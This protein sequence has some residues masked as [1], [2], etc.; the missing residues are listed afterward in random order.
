MAPSSTEPDTPAPEGISRAQVAADVPALLPLVD[1]CPGIH[2]YTAASPHYAALAEA[3]VAST[4]V[5]DRALVRPTSEVEVAAAVRVCGAAVAAGALPAL[6]I[7]NGAYDP[8]ERSR[9]EGGVT[10]DVRS[11]A[12]IDIAPDRRSVR[13]GGGVV[14]GT[15]LARLDRENLDTPTG[16]GAQIGYVGWASAGGYGLSV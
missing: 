16:W 11:L 4:D 15:L 6:A 2:I 13:I 9:T 8:G 5:F 7:R 1:E 12:A 3:S 10:L 14:L